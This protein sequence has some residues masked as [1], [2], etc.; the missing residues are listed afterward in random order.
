MDN[1]G[2]PE[3]AEKLD[4]EG[5]RIA[6]HLYG[7]DN[8]H[9][10]LELGDIGDSLQ[11]QSR[12]TEAEPIQRQ[13]VERMRK[14]EGPQAQHTL[15]MMTTLAITLAMQEKFAEAESLSRA[16]LA[17]SLQAQGPNARQTIEDTVNLALILAHEKHSAD[18]EELFKR[19]VTASAKAQGTL[20]ANVFY[21]YGEG[22]AI[23]GKPNEAIDYLKQAI[24]HGFSNKQ[25]MS[26]DEDL[27]P[28]QT[29]QRF[30]SDAGR[31]ALVWLR[32]S[33]QLT[34]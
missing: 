20:A 33:H 4:R 17:A 3:E 28:L 9:T 10:L 25:E 19:A 22:M 27:K 14:I 7:P 23:L 15:E 26:S 24:N 6:T 31:D 32:Q 21:A 18:S 34:K 12:L 2:H 13:V 30:Q 16:V 11:E 29:D 5:Y 1:E 8:E